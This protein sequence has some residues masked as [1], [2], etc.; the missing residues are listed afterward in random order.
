MGNGLFAEQVSVKTLTFHRGVLESP[1]V[2]LPVPN[3]PVTSTTAALKVTVSNDQNTFTTDMA[4][5][6]HDVALSSNND[7]LASLLITSIPMQVP[8][9]IPLTLSSPLTTVSDGPDPRECKSLLQFCPD[10]R[11]I[12]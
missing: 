4:I 11:L 2:P 12:R 3:K 8:S 5:S 9:Y 7:S 1:P 6:S 10:K